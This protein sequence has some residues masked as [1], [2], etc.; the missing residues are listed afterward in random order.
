MTF[1]LVD[2]ELSE[3]IMALSS[4]EYLSR[5]DTTMKEAAQISR[6]QSRH[7]QLPHL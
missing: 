6:Y 2:E 1:P 3:I 5:L 7:F 4:S